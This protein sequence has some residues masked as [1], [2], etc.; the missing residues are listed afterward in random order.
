MAQRALAA[1]EGQASALIAKIVRDRRAPAEFT[2]DDPTLLNFIAYQWGRTP[3][4]GVRGDVQLTKTMQAV[5]K[6]PVG[7]PDVLR[8]HA[9]E[10]VVRHSEPTLF[11]LSV[12]QRLGP[13]LFDLERAVLVNETDIEF[14]ASD[15][16]VVLHNQ[17]C[18]EVTWQGTTGFASHG[19]QVVLPLDSRHALLMFDPS[20]YA[21]GRQEHPASYVLRQQRDVKELNALQLS[22]A[23][24]NLYYSGDART[25]AS[26]DRLPFA[27][28]RGPQHTVAVH[29]G[30]D[31]SGSS[32]LI[33]T[34]SRS[35]ARLR[36]SFLR[37]LKAAKRVAVRER[38][39][40][41]RPDAMWLHRKLN[42][43]RGEGAERPAAGARAWTITEDPG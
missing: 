15:A 40:L 35:T 12:T 42:G 23:D 17:W 13:L 20:V 24:H 5:F 39:S 30:M 6:S 32:Q 21:I 14:I 41:Y 7:I 22:V 8:N 4:A 18:E 16:P 33:H 38:G 43:D 37:I 3:A 1:L 31:D 28:W 9:H 29:R 34:F 19:L 26:I 25:A 2:A 11:S 36:L 10:I 27:R